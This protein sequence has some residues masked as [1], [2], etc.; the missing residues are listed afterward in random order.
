MLTKEIDI[1]CILRTNPRV[2]ANALRRIDSLM[3]QLDRLG[4]KA[5]G[6]RLASPFC[7]SGRMAQKKSR[8]CRYCAEQTR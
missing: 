5:T 1:D 3:M 7:R 8:S 2:D 4:I 6:Y